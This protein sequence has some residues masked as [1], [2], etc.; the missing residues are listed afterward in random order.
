MLSSTYSTRLYR[1]RHLMY[2]LHFNQTMPDEA[3]VTDPL[4]QVRRLRL[5]EVEHL[6]IQ[7]S[8]DRIWAHMSRTPKL[9]SPQMSSLVMLVIGG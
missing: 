3:D 7:S 2:T 8:K 6:P 9:V 4:L 1:I 5:R